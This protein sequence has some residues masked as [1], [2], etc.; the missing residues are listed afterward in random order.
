MK[1]SVHTRICLSLKSCV[2]KKNSSLMPAWED[3]RDHILSTNCTY[4][5][6]LRHLIHL[7]ALMCSVQGSPCA[8]CNARLVM[9][10]SCH[11]T[12]CVAC[13]V[14]S[15]IG[16]QFSSDKIIIKVVSET[17]SYEWGNDFIHLIKTFNLRI[18][19]CMMQIW[20]SVCST[21]SP[22]CWMFLG[23]QDC[24]PA[25]LRQHRGCVVILKQEGDRC[26]HYAAC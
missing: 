19:V 22:M 5:G 18:V 14:C 23:S 20:T 2:R 10:Y 24:V 15:C 13:G 8:K 25:T 12:Q 3:T 9:I 16:A 21:S 1:K 17:C 11:N 7:V 4:T 26:L 6:Q